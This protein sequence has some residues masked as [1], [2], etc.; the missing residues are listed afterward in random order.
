MDQP[1][2]TAELVAE[3]GGIAKALGR[4]IA[5]STEARTLLGL[6]RPEPRVEE[7]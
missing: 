6:G 1:A 7:R 2:T 5:S 4:E 3:A